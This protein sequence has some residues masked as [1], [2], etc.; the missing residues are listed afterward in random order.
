VTARRGLTL[1]ELTVALAV[2]GV[3]LTVG[4]AALATLADHRAEAL[5]AADADDRAL[6]ARQLVTGW[7]TAARVGPGTEFAATSRERRTPTGVIAD[8]SLSFV[9]AADGIPRRVHLFVDR[10]ASPAA[11]VAE[12]ESDRGESARIVLAD[13][14][15]GVEARVLS[16]AFGV[17][18]WRRAWIGAL[19]PSAVSLRLQGR[20]GASLPLALRMPIT[21]ALASAP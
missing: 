6:A 20:D 14:I 12:L 7:V 3:A 5:A 9:T 21:I 8:D 16:A 11:F 2:G 4:S 17:R 18:A 15:V 13:S 10:R 1:L 19:R